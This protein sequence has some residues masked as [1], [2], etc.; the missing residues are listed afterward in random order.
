M[1]ALLGLV[2]VAQLCE[3]AHARPGQAAFDSDV[4]VSVAGR[5]SDSIIDFNQTFASMVVNATTN[6]M[7]IV[8]GQPTNASSTCAIRQEHALHGCADSAFSLPRSAVHDGANCSLAMLLNSTTTLQI[9]IN[10]RLPTAAALANYTLQI[11][12]VQPSVLPN[13]QPRRAETHDI[14]IAIAM[15]SIGLGALLA[16]AIHCCRNQTKASE[17]AQHDRLLQGPATNRAT[18]SASWWSANREQVGFT[19][20]LVLVGLGQAAGYSAETSFIGHLGK[21]AMAARSLV[22]STMD[23]FW[24]ISYLWYAVSTKIARSVGEGD[25]IAIAKLFK[26]S[27]ILALACSVVTMVIVYAIGPWMIRTLYDPSE[28]VYQ[29]AWP[30]L[31]IHAAGQ[32]LDYANSMGKSTAQG[33]QYLRAFLLFNFI[34]RA[35]FQ[36]WSNYVCINVLKLGVNGSAYAHV[37]RQV[38]MAFL[39]FGL[40]GRHF[41]NEKERLLGSVSIWKTVLHREDWKIFSVHSFYLLGVLLFVLP[42]IHVAD[43]DT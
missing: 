3:A 10:S 34:E 40:L 11:H 29:L 39:W 5:D 8:S 20:M 15:A 43:H 27:M 12:A 32:P 22:F 16:G 24:G 30:F 19:S 42:H 33:L 9:Q 18:A 6:T 41:N 4:V 13:K 17:S 36:P 35:V 26:M 23:Y 21:D 31:F 2:R 1:L 25:A 14:V 38:F 28:A 37:A 7:V